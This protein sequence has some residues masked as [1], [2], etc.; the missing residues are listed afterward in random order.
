[1]IVCS[2]LSGGSWTLQRYSS[3]FT[4]LLSLAIL[5]F[6]SYFQEGTLLEYGLIVLWELIENQTPYI[7]GKEADVFSLLLWIRYSGKP[8]VIPSFTLT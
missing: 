4:D 3:A 5:S 6:D 8:N 7:E 2:K 1:M